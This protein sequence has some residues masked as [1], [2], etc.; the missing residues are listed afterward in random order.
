MKT[1]YMYDIHNELMQI[2]K[3]NAADRSRGAAMIMEHYGDK[4]MSDTLRL[5][6]GQLDFD[7][8]SEAK[9]AIKRT[10][11]KLD[12]LIKERKEHYSSF[13]ISDLT[14]DM[15]LAL[16]SGEVTDLCYS[17]VESSFLKNGLFD[18]DIFGGSGKIPYFD[19]EHRKYSIEEYGTGMGHIQLPCH[20]VLES[21]YWIIADLLG[22]TVKDIKNLAKYVSVVVT[23][24]GISGLK[25]GT[26]LTEKEYAKYADKY[27]SVDTGGDAIYNMLKALNYSDKPERMAFSVIPVI[28]P[29]ARPMAYSLKEEIYYC[30]PLNQIYE[31]I[32]NLSQRFKRLQGF[33]I[34]SVISNNERRMID[35][36]VNELEKTISKQN[37]KKLCKNNFYA[38]HNFYQRMIA[39]RRSTVNAVYIP[40]EKKGEIES[41]GI[42]P[43][44][45]RVK[46]NAGTYNNVSFKHIIDTCD[47]AM[48]LFEKNHTVVI[49]ND[50]DPDH[51]PADLQ[52]KVNESEEGYHKMKVTLDAIFEGA[53]TQREVFTVR[54]DTSGMYVPCDILTLK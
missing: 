26:I 43:E 29:T 25:V 20:V 41:L 44:T 9:D 18:P 5:L 3:N 8:S 21:N 45:I 11:E 27:M 1:E 28:S 34:S 50:V 19:D 23:N 46:S 39:C 51:L 53:K 49:P 7:D 15:V 2:N 42:Y 6:S 4:E 48:C 16:S 52:A 13:Y 35:S 32:V 10:N 37:V 40:S 12:R 14:D 17:S 24:P 54:Y 36:A 30:D 22:Q 38:V 33:G 47:D 31:K